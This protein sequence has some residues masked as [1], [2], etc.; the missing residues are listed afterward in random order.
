MHNTIY[1]T[2]DTQII[3]IPKLHSLRRFISVYLKLGQHV[4]IKHPDIS[5]VT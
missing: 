1:D 5:E 4:L 2:Y 3:I